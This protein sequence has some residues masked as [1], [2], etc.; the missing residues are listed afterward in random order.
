MNLTTILYFI[1]T[2]LSVW[3]ISSLNLERY[4][5][6]NA[7]SIQMVL[8][9]LLLAMAL[10]YLVVNFFTDFYYSTITKY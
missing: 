4:F 10:S 7:K 3:C 9:Y 2:P 5:R 6:K 8:T 1:V